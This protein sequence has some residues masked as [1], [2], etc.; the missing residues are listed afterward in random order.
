MT[1]TTIGPF[2]K[3][4]FEAFPDIRFESAGMTLARGEAASWERVTGTMLGPMTDV[5]TG[6]KVQPDRAAL[7]PADRQAP[8]VRPRP[9]HPRVL[10]HLGSSGAARAARASQ[11]P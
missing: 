9:S 10:E 3:G 7:L 6:K 11:G 2:F 1:A 4:V 5:A 8:A